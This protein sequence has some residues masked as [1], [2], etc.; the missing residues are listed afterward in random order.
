MICHGESLAFELCPPSL[1]KMQC[2]CTWTGLLPVFGLQI[3]LEPTLPG[4]S[5]EAV[6]TEIESDSKIFC[7]PQVFN[8]LEISLSILVLIFTACVI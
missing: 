3:R 1:L 7:K 4:I 6:L 5:G 8:I 2:N